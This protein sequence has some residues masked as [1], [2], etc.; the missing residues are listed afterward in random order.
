MTSEI[1]PLPDP[2]M[3]SYFSPPIIYDGGSGGFGGPGIISVPYGYSGQK[4]NCDG[5][6]ILDWGHN[7]G[8]GPH[9]G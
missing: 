9:N 8:K 4:N 6:L 2:R 7:Y 1:V 5:P 3:E